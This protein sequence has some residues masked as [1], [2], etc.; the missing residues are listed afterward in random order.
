MPNSIETV[1][2]RLARAYA[3]INEQVTSDD[4]EVSQRAAAVA[5][6]LYAAAAQLAS[7]SERV[8]LLAD[9]PCTSDSDA[10]EQLHEATAQLGDA[11]TSQLGAAVRHL[12]QA[13]LL[14]TV[15][16]PRQ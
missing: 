8:E 7:V 12:E 14:L 6:E 13:H 11:G 2:L 16:G 15:T 5:L 3:Y 9:Y 10:A 1:Q 4:L